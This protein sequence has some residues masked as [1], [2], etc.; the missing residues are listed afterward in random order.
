MIHPLRMSLAPGTPL[1][2]GPDMAALDATLAGG[3]T[4]SPRPW[5]VIA[6]TRSPAVYVPENG[7]AA[8]EAVLRRYKVRWLLLVGDECLGESQAICR[9]LLSGER[10][11]VGGATITKRLAR[12]DLTLFDVAF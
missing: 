11:K 8:I 9:Q 6:E 5:S 3:T 1:P 2:F 12:G 4:M 10:Q 7:E